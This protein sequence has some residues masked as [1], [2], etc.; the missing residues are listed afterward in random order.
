MNMNGYDES[1]RAVITE[2]ISRV[3]TATGF[4]FTYVG[5]STFIPVEA[6]PWGY[7]ADDF[8]N[9]TAPFDIIIS[10]A[11]EGITDLVAG[12]VGRPGVAGLGT[13]P[14]RLGRSLLRRLGDDRHGR[15]RLG[16]RCGPATASVRV[17][18]HELGHAMGLG[19]VTDPTQIMNSFARTGPVRTPTARVICAACGCP[20]AHLGCANFGPGSPSTSTRSAIHSGSA[21]RYPRDHVARRSSRAAARG[22]RG[23]PRGDRRPERAGRADGRGAEPLARPLPATSSTPMPTPAAADQ[24]AAAHRE[25]AQAGTCSGGAGGHGH[26]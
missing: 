25:G 20:A 7:P 12:S 4:Q 17:L 5:D 3:A 15:P 14:P 22:H 6:D 1:F 13:D 11:N 18:L 9:G 8:I 24:A 16:T 21:R 19:H 23:A 2:A 10:L 26:P